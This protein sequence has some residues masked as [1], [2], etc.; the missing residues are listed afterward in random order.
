ME[1]ETHQV[2]TS[3][4]TLPP[5]TTPHSR[6]ISVNRLRGTP[7]PPM[8]PTE[9]TLND[10]HSSI[11]FGPE[12]EILNGL[13]IQ[14]NS[15]ADQ[16]HIRVTATAETIHD[17]GAMQGSP[18]VM[19]V[20]G[21]SVGGSEGYGLPMA[22]EEDINN[23]STTPKYTT[24]TYA[25]PIKLIITTSGAL[26]H[27]NQQYRFPDDVLMAAGRD[28]V[29]YTTI[30]DEEDSADA[31]YDEL[32]NS[33]DLAS[34]VAQHEANVDTT[35]TQDDIGISHHHHNVTLLS[36]APTTTRYEEEVADEQVTGVGEDLVYEI[37]SDS[38]GVGGGVMG[39]MVTDTVAQFQDVSGVVGGV[40]EQEE[41][42]TVK[43]SFV[44]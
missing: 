22:V 29:G 24:T 10:W 13:Q 17:D 6:Y 14:T 19:I 20:N 40:G 37:M 21:V 1:H 27:H 26:G 4:P 41:E 38:V 3:T 18:N 8:P 9:D 7:R 31:A 25:N 15:Q 5:T 23:G 43:V 30:N 35:L 11:S 2:T 36:A 32:N 28:T 16:I 42:A 12:N 39:G 44:F 34:L 33:L